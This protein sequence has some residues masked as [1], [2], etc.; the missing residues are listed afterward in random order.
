MNLQEWLSHCE[1]LHPQNIDMG[2]ERVSA[3][4]L[5]MGLQFASPVITV[6]GTNGKGSTCAM[7]E[8]ILRQAGYRTGMFSSPHLV[9]FEERCKIEGQAV[10]SSVLVAHFAKVESARG[11]ISLSYF[12]FTSLAIFSCLANAQLD[13]VILEVGLG[14]RLDAVN[15]IDTDCAIITSIDIDHTEWLGPDRESIGREKAGIM[16]SSKPVIL[17]DP[18]PPTSVA[19]HAAQVGA[20]LWQSGSDFH[21]SGDQQQWRWQ[22]AGRT[23]AGLAYPALRGVNQLVNAAGVLAALHALRET[24]PVNAQA[25]RL[26]LSR[27]E[28]AGRFQM[29]PGQPALVLDVAHN[30]HAVAALAHNLDAMGF[31]AVTRVVMGAMA[32]KDLQAMVQRLQPLVTHWYFCD[33]PSARAATA[34]QLQS[35]WQALPSRQG[36]SAKTFN[37]PVAALDQ[38]M[39]DADPTDRILVFGSFLTVGGVL[40][41]GIAGRLPAQSPPD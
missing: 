34:V 30:P 32:D 8:S 40:Q 17:S 11:D 35:V 4:A 20:V 15:A 28:W 19:Q 24:L 22:G 39:A 25:I 2:L 3:V 21:F 33:L 31:F 12:E 26:G 29:L 10:P 9:Y 18:H 1:R 23:W 16:R 14:G 13:V 27:V 38:A 41:H 6:A 37:D 36:Q 5:K 7:L